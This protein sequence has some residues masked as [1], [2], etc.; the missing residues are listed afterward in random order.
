MCNLSGSE[1]RTNDSK[2]QTFRTKLCNLD[3]ISNLKESL[4]N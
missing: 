1:S 3:D 4:N 2:S